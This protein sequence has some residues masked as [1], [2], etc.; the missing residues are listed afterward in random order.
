VDRAAKTN[1]ELILEEVETALRHASEADDRALK[2][3]YR[4]I[5]EHY[6][7]L[8][9]VWGCIE[10]AKAISAYPLV[11]QVTRPLRTRAVKR[12]HFES[13]AWRYPSRFF[14]SAAKSSK[15]RK[16]VTAT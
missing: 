4:D 10:R 14:T 5:A 1:A 7:W 3:V 9:H 12:R 15:R 16:G 11:A 8:V 13:G 6:L 2:N